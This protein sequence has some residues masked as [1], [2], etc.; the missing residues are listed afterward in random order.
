MRVKTDPSLP[1]VENKLSTHNF[2]KELYIEGIRKVKEEGYSVRSILITRAAK[3]PFS[4]QIPLKL[5]ADWD[6][7]LDGADMVILLRKED[8]N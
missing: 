6:P 8:G 5:V 4:M 7:Q 1:S 2:N 3:P